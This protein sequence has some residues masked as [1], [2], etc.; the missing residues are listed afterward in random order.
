MLGE[1]IKKIRLSKSLTIKDLADSTGLTVGYL[2]NLERGEKTNPSYEVIQK[3]AN[4][5]SVPMVDFYKEE[6]PKNILGYNIKRI[7]KEKNITLKQLEDITGI[8][9]S[10][11]SDLENSRRVNPS[12]EKLEMLANALNV[13]LIDFYS[14]KKTSKNFLGENIKKIRLSKNL[15]MT[16]LE[17]LSGVKSSYISNIENGKRI[18]PSQ[19]TLEKLAEALDTT[20]S[21][22]YSKNTEYKQEVKTIN[23]DLAEIMDYLKK[24]SIYYNGM[25][26]EEQEISFLNASINATI[27]QIK[28]MRRNK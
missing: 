12:V 7:R 26:L 22:L 14:E 16:K 10:Y 24:D 20:V 8:S 2:S 6:P 3:I 23:N 25:K 21:E 18:N 28:L 1:N 17:S 9:N 11:I 15:S 13:N 4:A 27:E 19:E 5:L